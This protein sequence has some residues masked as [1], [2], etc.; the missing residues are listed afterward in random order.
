MKKYRVV[1]DERL[2]Y[3]A[4]DIEANSEEEAEEKFMKLWNNGD[5][6]VNDSEIAKLGIE[7]LA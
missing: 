7:E 1:C 5:I 2:Y 6:G 3:N 4:T